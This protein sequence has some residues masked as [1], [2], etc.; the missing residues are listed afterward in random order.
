MR[1]YPI[2]LLFAV[3]IV[4]NAFMFAPV[5]AADRVCNFRA[6][7]LSLNF[8]VLNPSV[9]Q[10]IT[11]PVTVATTFADMAGDCI[12][13]GNMTISVSGSNSR[14]LV[15]GP[16]TINYTIT[17]LPISLPQPGNAPNNNPSLGYVTWFTPSSQL[18]GNILW[19]AFANAP[20][21]NYSDS[22]TI[23]INP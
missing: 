23:L 15:S 2:Q 16:N 19:S 5:H 18:Q 11:Q 14:Q 1:F 9:V 10:N 3:F 12:G 22:V 13:S 7:G 20:A 4:L 21:G 8:G 17:G 6:K